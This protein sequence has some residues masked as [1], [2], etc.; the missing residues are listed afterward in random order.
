MGDPNR[1]YLLSHISRTA[2]AE[3]NHTSVSCSGLPG[4]RYSDQ[5]CP[6]SSDSLKRSTAGHRLRWEFTT[7]VHTA[8]GFPHLTK[9]EK[10]FFV[11]QQLH[12]QFPKERPMPL[13]SGTS[14]QPGTS[15]ELRNPQRREGV[16]ATERVPE[17]LP[18]PSFCHLPRRMNLNA[19]LYFTGHDFPIF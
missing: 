11:P 18:R 4:D 16:R 5:H 6:K 3:G 1:P 10:H 17:S 2:T 19:S 13:T 14:S 8:L 15:R 7:G 9:G 12:F